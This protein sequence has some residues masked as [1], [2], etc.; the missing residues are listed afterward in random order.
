MKQVLSE[1]MM[2][3]V[4]ATG[5]QN[6]MTLWIILAAV[7]GAAIGVALFFINKKKDK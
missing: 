4:P 2:S 7:A 5:D 3:A 6:N 1:L